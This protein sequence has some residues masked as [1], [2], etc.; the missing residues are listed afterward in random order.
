MVIVLD[1][2]R[3]EASLPKGSPRGH[4]QSRNHR[5]PFTL[6]LRLPPDS[7][8]CCHVDR[9]SWKRHEVSGSGDTSQEIL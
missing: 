2:K 5:E 7:D 3:L 4:L 6:Q 8:C 9:H 1:G